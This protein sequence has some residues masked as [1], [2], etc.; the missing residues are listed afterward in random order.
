M[1]YLHRSTL[2]FFITVFSDID[3]TEYDMAEL[4]NNKKEY[5][6]LFHLDHTMRVDDWKFFYNDLK[7][8]KL[9]PVIRIFDNYISDE[10][11]EFIKEGKAYKKMYVGNAQ[12]DIPDDSL[13]LPYKIEPLYKQ[14]HEFPIVWINKFPYFKKQVQKYLDN[15]KNRK[16]S[17]EPDYGIYSFEKQE[18]EFWKYCLPLIKEYGNKITVNGT[19]KHCRILELIISMQINKNIKVIRNYYK[20]NEDTQKMDSFIQLKFYSKY[21]ERIKKYGKGII[22]HMY[23]THNWPREIPWDVWTTELEGKRASYKGKAFEFKGGN[24]DQKQLFDLLIL[25]KGRSTMNKVEEVLDKNVTPKYVDD[26]LRHIVG[27]AKKVVSKKE[28]INFHVQKDRVWIVPQLDN[29]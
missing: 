4:E 17:D 27:K 14:T 15:F 25:Q 5:R 1:Q 23:K 28:V 24:T 13:M 29:N 9:L 18:K 21:Y 20:E 26:M 6:G 19:I 10:S 11:K 3:K 7:E 22:S 2:Q 8:M 16:L 12:G